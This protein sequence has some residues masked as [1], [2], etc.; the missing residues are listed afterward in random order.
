MAVQQVVTWTPLMDL[1]VL[2]LLFFADAPICATQRTDNLIG[3]TAEENI[4]INCQV[5]KLRGSLFCLVVGK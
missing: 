4:S 3:V 1:H 5:R 2:T